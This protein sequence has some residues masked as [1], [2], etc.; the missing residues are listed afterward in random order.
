MTWLWDRLAARVDPR[1]LGV[2]RIALGVAALLTWAIA[3]GGLI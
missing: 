3:A 1:P 2:T